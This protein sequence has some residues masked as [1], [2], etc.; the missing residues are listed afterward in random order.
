MMSGRPAGEP[1][2]SAAKLRVYLDATIIR[3]Y[4][5]PRGAGPLHGLIRQTVR[6]EVVLVVSDLTVDEL[7]DAPAEVHEVMDASILPHAERVSI[8]TEALELADQY[9]ESG[10]VARPRRADARHVAAATVAG[11]DVLA[12]WNRRILNWERIRRHNE[13]NRMMGYGPIDARDPRALEYGMSDPEPAIELPII[14]PGERGFRVMP[15]LRAL[16]ARIY[17]KTKDMTFAERPRWSEERR[18]RDP[19]LSN[20]WNS[21]QKPERADE[22]AGGD[23]R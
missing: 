23:G 10:V 4:Q 11:A 14:E 5:D 3:A 16:R 12:S 9:V 20:W 8:T 22:L 19:W 1:I 7:R 13:V 18:S 17:E 21:M 15:W 2:E 6:D